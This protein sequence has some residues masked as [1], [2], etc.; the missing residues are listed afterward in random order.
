ML[1]GYRDGYDKINSEWNRI[2]NLYKKVIKFINANL[3]RK[4]E[5]TM[6]DTLPYLL[7]KTKIV[8]FRHF[9]F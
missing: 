3:A 7:G 4:Y 2:N 1:S 9:D 6:N 8:I 5:I